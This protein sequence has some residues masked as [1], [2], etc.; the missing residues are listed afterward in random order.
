MPTDRWGKLM[1]DVSP[2]ASIWDV[3]TSGPVISGVVGLITG[4]IGSFAPWV[5][6]G[7]E[8]RRGKDQYR[9]EQIA[10]WRE[11]LR[12]DF[13]RRSFVGSEAYSTLK[14]HM[15]SHQE[16][17]EEIERSRNPDHRVLLSGSDDPMRFRLLE[18]VAEVERKWGLI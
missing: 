7:V 15:S 12:G 6:W 16:L 13:D 14:S 11:A 2:Y 18:V 5:V 17:V 3:I 1:A 10:R 9:R 8:K 4:A